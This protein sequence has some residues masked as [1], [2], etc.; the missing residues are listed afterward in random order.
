[1]PPLPLRIAAA[2]VLIALYVSPGLGHASATKLRAEGMT[3]TGSS[4]SERQVILHS[5]LAV[6]RPADGIAELTD[7]EAEVSVLDEG[8]SFT[9]K[10]DEAELDVR[11][12]DFSARGDVHGQTAEGQ[13]YRAPWVDYDHEQGLLSTDAPVVMED[14]SGSFRG[15]GFRYH[16]REKRFRLLGNVRVEQTP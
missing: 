7:V 2:A 13:R 8:L 10:C 14:H 9:M 15:D 4:G 6:F 16:I 1:M 3:F 12:N 5:R 11:S